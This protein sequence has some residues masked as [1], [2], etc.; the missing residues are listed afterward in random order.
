MTTKETKSQRIQRLL[1]EHYA[2][3]EALAKELGNQ[4]PNGKK[5]SVALFKL[6]TEANGRALA[7]CNGELPMAQFEHFKHYVTRTIGKLFGQVPAGFFVNSDARGY[8]LKIDNENAQGKALIEA[9][10]MHKDWGGYGI[11]SPEIN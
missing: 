8:A 1:N 5:I 2:R 10:Q 3:C 11:L 6:E 7:Y 9:C 4:S